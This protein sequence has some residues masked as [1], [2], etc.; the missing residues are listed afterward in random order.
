[1]ADVQEVS[2]RHEWVG[3]TP[4]NHGAG[5]EVIGEGMGQ[6]LVLVRFGEVT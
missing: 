4:T 6:A 3:A 5:M 2:T 1:M